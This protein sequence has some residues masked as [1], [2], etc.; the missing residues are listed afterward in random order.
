MLQITS[1]RDT[2]K[3]KYY[4]E[5]F[6]FKGGKKLV[7]VTIELSKIQ[8]QMLI[9]CIESALDTKHVPDDKEGGAKKIIEQ[10]NKYL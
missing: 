3:L 7:K 1:V 4:I 5:I 8:I 10:L 9:N 6:N 2:F